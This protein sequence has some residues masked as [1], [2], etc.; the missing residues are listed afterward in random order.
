MIISGGVGYLTEHMGQEAPVS[1]AMVDQTGS[2]FPY[3][4]N[5]LQEGPLT[6]TLYD[7]SVERLEEGLSEGRYDYHGYIVVNDESVMTGR[8]TYR[9]ADMRNVFLQN[10]RTQLTP[11]FTQY[12][13]ER[14]GFSPE[15]ITTVAQPIVIEPEA[16]SGEEHSFGQMVAPM[17]LGMVLVFAAIFSGQILMYG[18]IKEKQ[19]RIV[20]ILLSSVS[21]LELLLGKIVGFGLLSLLQVSIWVV[22]GLIAVN[23]LTD[24]PDLGLTLQDFILPLVFFFFG[25]LM[26]GALFAAAGATMKEA[27]GGSQAQGLI[28]IIPMLP[29]FLA[30]PLILNPNALWVRI[31]SH[32]PPFIPATM[33][34]RMA[35]VTFP[36]WEIISTLTALVLS[37]IFFIYLGAKI[38]EGGIMHYERSLT[39]RDLR[40][41]LR[42][43]R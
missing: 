26:L 36:L 3:L 11:P 34:M 23:A 6:V 2:F 35:E 20:E 12:R 1:L 42:G 27:E 21:S 19:N 24:M 4:E 15:Q 25:Y 33:F 17:V 22:A 7:G 28:L 43:H 38:F 29:V 9:V 40:G 41:I 13:L 14:M 32:V 30:G 10:I 5:H 16:I 39:L 8:L 37:V 31:L 18:V